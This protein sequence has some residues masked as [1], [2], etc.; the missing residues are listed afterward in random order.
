MGLSYD[1][2]Y[3]MPICQLKTLIAIQ[4]IKEEGLDYVPTPDEEKAEFLRLLAIK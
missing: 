4:Q 3:N 1:E 2:T